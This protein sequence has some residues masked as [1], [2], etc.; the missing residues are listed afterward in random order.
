MVYLYTK[1]FSVPHRCVGDLGNLGGGVKLVLTQPRWAPPYHSEEEKEK[2]DE[3]RTEN[4]TPHNR[5]SA[6]TEKKKK[7]GELYRELH[8]FCSHRR[9]H[10][11][12]KQ[13][14]NGC[15]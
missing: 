1:N 8:Q 4:N 2:G 11:P 13:T 6:H 9:W 15:R 12:Q 5:K 14:K 7:Q 10:R 3:Q